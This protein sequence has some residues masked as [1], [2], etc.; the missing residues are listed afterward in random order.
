[1]VTFTIIAFWVVVGV[2]AL[3]AGVAWLFTSDKNGML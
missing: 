3:A 2:A 1:M